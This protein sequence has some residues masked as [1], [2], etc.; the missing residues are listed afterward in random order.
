MCD[1]VVMTFTFRVVSCVW[2][3]FKKY[4]HVVCFSI[5]RFGN[6]LTQFPCTEHEHASNAPWYDIGCPYLRSCCAL[7]SQLSPET[8]WNTQGKVRWVILY[9]LNNRLKT[10]HHP[11]GPHGSRA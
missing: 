3:L 7:R 9:H 4:T 8:L 5:A 10:P 2:L 6:R 1:T 11:Q